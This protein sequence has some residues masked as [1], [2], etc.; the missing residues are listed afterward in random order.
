MRPV[1]EGKLTD[2]EQEASARVMGVQGCRILEVGGKDLE[3]GHHHRFSP[4][5]S[6]PKTRPGVLPEALLGWHWPRAPEYQ[7][8][9]N[10]IPSFKV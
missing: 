2:G 7:L 10:A 3:C 4:W 5:G 1:W 9:Q 6:A 8:S